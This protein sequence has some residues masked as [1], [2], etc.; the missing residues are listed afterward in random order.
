MEE[1]VKKIIVDAIDEL[2]EQLDDGKKLAYGEDV[3]LI[4]K[5]ASI[6]SME[7]VTFI[8]IIE[9]LISDELDEDI[10]IVS[11]KA[12]SRERSPFL[13]LQS[14]EEFIVEILEEGR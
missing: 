7:F 3:K 2:N 6:D 9:E 12:F 14:L 5:N 11:D 4:G 8:T 13:S 10:R 1:K